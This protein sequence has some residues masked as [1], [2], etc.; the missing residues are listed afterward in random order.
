MKDEFN[1]RQQHPGVPVA[2]IAFSLLKLS[3]LPLR[4]SPRFAWS[5]LSEIGVQVL[6]TLFEPVL[7]GE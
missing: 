1:I 2:I 6:E 3:D 7:K 4:K 5:E